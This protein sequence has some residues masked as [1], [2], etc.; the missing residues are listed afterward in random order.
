M[1]LLHVGASSPE[2]YGGDYDFPIRE[3]PNSDDWIN[4]GSNISKT[5]YD[6][7][8]KE[9]GNKWQMPT[10]DEII[11]LKQYCNIFK[12]IMK[13]TNGDWVIVLRV[14]KLKILYFYL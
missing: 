14:K 9:W 6:V 7:A 1:G 5:K 13:N 10:Y 11:E 12:S 3:L 2:Q 4:I 8:Y